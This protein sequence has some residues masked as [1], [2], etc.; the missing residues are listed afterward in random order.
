[1]PIRKGDPL[2]LKRSKT[3]TGKTL[4]G[5]DRSQRLKACSN[6]AEHAR[7]ASRRCWRHRRRG[8]CKYYGCGLV[9]PETLDG[10]GAFR[11]LG[12]GFR[13]RRL[14][15]SELVG[16]SGEVVGVD[17]TP[18]Q[19]ESRRANIRSAYRTGSGAM[20]ARTRFASLQG[21]IEISTRSALEPVKLRRVIVSNCVVHLSIRQTVGVR[22]ASLDLVETRRRT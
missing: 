12:C 18:E 19:L 11:I 6:A 17:M 4:R 2:T 20:M 1:M 3:I 7:S 10:R 14:A 9:V 15:P 22:R 16:A 13:P 8:A 21:D 5:S